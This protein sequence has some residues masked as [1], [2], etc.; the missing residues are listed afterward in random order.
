MFVSI[1]VTGTVSLFRQGAAACGIT[2]A[3]NSTQLFNTVISAIALKNPFRDR[4][5]C[6]GTMR[7]FIHKWI[8]KRSSIP[9]LNILV[10]REI[11]IN[12]LKYVIFSIICT[13]KVHTIRM[14]VY[15]VYTRCCYCNHVNY[16]SHRS[17][18]KFDGQFYCILLTCYRSRANKYFI[19]NNSDQDNV[20]ASILNCCG[21][22]R[23]K[24][25]SAP[26]DNCTC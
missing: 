18:Q 8:V 15:V 12:F 23:E 13:F 6:I 17:H 26:R 3:V 4:S 19:S 16:R 9:T 1:T 14:L 10:K 20:V 22:R 7:L 5:I 21:Q 25:V 24:I 11:R 2:L